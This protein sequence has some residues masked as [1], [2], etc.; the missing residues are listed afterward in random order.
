[1]NVN[2]YLTIR[3]CIVVNTYIYILSYITVLK[4]YKYLNIKYI[5]YHYV[6]NY[7]LDDYL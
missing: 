3:R 6:M 7:S 1:M 5:I 2:Y 4:Y